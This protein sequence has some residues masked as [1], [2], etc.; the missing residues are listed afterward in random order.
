MDTRLTLTVFPWL[1]WIATGGA[2]LLGA[3][4]PNVTGAGCIAL[5]LMGI[6]RELKLDAQA[7]LRAQ[8][9][10]SAAVAECGQ[11]AELERSLEDANRIMR[12]GAKA[13]QQMLEEIEALKH[14]LA[15]ALDGRAAEANA[16]LDAEDKLARMLAA[17]PALKALIDSTEASR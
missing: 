4:F 3:Y 2:Q 14:D 1:V 6:L 12:N 17:Q 13:S 16:R 11:C 8:A 5:G 9:P 7:R 10:A 15:Q